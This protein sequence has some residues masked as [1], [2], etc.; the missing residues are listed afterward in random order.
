MRERERE[1]ETETRGPVWGHDTG[2]NF[3]PNLDTPAD[4]CDDEARGGGHSQHPTKPQHNRCAL[5][6]SPAHGEPAKRERERER[7]RER[8]GER[9]LR[10][11]RMTR[12]GW[13]Q[14][15]GGDQYL[16]GSARGRWGACSSVITGLAGPRHLPATT[17]GR[18]T[19]LKSRSHP[20]FLQSRFLPC[21]SNFS[22]S[23]NTV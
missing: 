20:F 22:L 14:P 8:G 12:D 4:I 19:L 2:L 16:T 10:K 11:G 15:G 21:A 23:Q 6:I 17:A 1:C 7:K 9:A 13:G 3:Q 5:S 18:W